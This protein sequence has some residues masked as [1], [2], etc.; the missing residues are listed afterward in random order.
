LVVTAAS[1]SLS[2]AASAQD[3]AVMTRIA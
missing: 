2:C 3:G 1:G